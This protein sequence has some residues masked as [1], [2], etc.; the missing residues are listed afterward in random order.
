MVAY[1]SSMEGLVLEGLVIES[2][3]ILGFG[4]DGINRGEEPQR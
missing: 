4:L 1:A 3:V 2:L